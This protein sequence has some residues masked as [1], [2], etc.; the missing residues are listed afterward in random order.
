[1]KFG[2]T[3]QE[4]SFIKKSLEPLKSQGAKIWCYGSRARGD[5]HKFSDL[6][7]MVEHDTDLSKVVSNISEFFEDSNFPYKVD[8]VE[9]RNFA[10]SYLPSFERDK[11]AF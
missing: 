7:L 10:K 6:D 9:K 5:H 1:M 8:L 11:V 4:Y 2:L 3:I